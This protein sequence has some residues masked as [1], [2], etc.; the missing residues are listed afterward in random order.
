[1][2][3]RRAKP[4]SAGR[5]NLDR[6]GKATEPPFL[7]TKRSYG[8]RVSLSRRAGLLRLALDADSVGHAIDVVEVG[9]HLDRVADRLVA[10]AVTPQAVDVRLL[11]RRGPERQPDGEVTE[12]AERWFER[13]S[14]VVALGV[15][16]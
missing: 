15:V 13:R 12:R 1:M 16:G 10:P 4:V 7:A 3:L 9:D 2:L 8:A 14:A 11:D 5:A 6:L